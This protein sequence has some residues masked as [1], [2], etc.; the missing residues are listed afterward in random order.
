MVQEATQWQSVVSFV[1]AGMGVSLAPGCV[2]RFRW[3]G[4]AYRPLRKLQT[5]VL[6]C[7]HAGNVPATVPGFL[8][9]AQAEFARARLL[10]PAH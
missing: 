6:A 5:A 9:L 8:R 1:E 10:H 2:Q 3:K 7:W 4:V